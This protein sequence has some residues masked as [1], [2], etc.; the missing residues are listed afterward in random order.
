MPTDLQI[1]IF[2]KRPSAD[3]IMNGLRQIT[4]T[5]AVGL[6]LITLS[7]CGTNGTDNAPTA[8]PQTATLIRIG[9]IPAGKG[10]YRMSWVD[11]KKGWLAD[12]Q[13]IW[14]TTD[15]GANWLSVYFA[16]TADP[17]AEIASLQFVDH[18]TGWM[19]LGDHVVQTQDGGATWIP[20]ASLPTPAQPWTVRF[21]PD[22]TMGWIV[23]G[24]FERVPRNALRKGGFRNNVVSPD[25]SSVIFPMILRTDDHGATWHTQQV[26]RRP[27]RLFDLFV[28]DATNVWAYGDAG[29]FRW[30]GFRWEEADPQG[31]NCPTSGLARTEDPS[32]VVYDP[33]A[34]YFLNSS[35]GWLSFGNG[36][37]AKTSDSG[38]TWCDLLNPRDLWPAASYDS[39]FTTLHFSDPVNGWALGLNGRLYRTRTGGSSWTTVEAGS[40]LDDVF[41]LDASHAWAVGKD[42]LFGFAPG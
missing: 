22:G 25:G 1:P 11:D 17:S 10:E 19:I 32:N 26:S 12:S 31:G 39:F 6:L 16:S 34:L 5:S 36:F 14:R 18:N 28:I 8:P 33:M 21:L 30:R 15:G 37:V 42:G 41:F 9:T 24:R 20:R 40:P 27:G 13:Q 7:T 4:K 2:R 38:E 35:D 29:I 3:K 23:G